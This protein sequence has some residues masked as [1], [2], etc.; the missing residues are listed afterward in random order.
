MGDPRACSLPTLAFA[1]A[2][3][4]TPADSAIAPI[5]LHYSGLLLLRPDAVAE[6]RRTSIADGDSRSGRLLDDGPL[7]GWMLEAMKPGTKAPGFAGLVAGGSLKV[8]LGVGPLAFGWTALYR[9]LFRSG[10]VALRDGDFRF[11]DRWR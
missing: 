6:C 8:C 3:P 9:S 1:S 4:D 11:Y 2:R 5:R 7:N 10:F